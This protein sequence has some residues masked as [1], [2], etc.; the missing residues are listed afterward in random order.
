M[1]QTPQ[2]ST[3]QTGYAGSDELKRAKMELLTTRERGNPDALK[4][5]LARY[6]QHAAALVE[7]SA[8]LTATG[9]YADV[10][11]T[12]ETERIATQART[13][14]FAAVFGAPV[15]ALTPAFASLKALRN[16]RA[17]S[18]KAVAERLGLGVDV[19]S[20]LEAG[21]IRARSVPNRLLAA[22]GD[23]LDTTAEQIGALLGAQTALA[24]AYQ[25]AKT[26]ET[27]DGAISAQAAQ[28]DFADVVQMSP[29]MTSEQKV[30]WLDA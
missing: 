21:R 20:A 18:L 25:R 22:L 10:T 9:A 15:A 13:T 28:L 24:P 2:S 5:T 16:V 12:P 29:S 17:L 3:S 11:P 19:L 4:A 26:G 8:A 6:P 1:F 7:F 27:K 14:A 30:A 23:M